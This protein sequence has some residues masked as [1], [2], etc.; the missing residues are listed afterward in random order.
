MKY[1]VVV[2]RGARSYGAFAPDIPGA[3]GLG[4]SREEALASVAQ[5]L[6]L[7]LL[8]LAERGLEPPPPSDPAALELSAFEPE[9]PF[10]IVVI[11]PAPTNPVS[12]EIER[13]IRETGLS[14]A[15][16]ARR[17]GTSRAAM[18]RITDPFYWGHSLRTLTKLAKALDAELEIQLK[19]KAA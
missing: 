11:E 4:D 15:D 13:A 7:Q 2:E 18:T 17:M 12:L 14:E 9:E 1:S 19:P 6:A 16:V 10:E 5:S 8:D 3:V